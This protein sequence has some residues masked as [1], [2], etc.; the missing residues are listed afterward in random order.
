MTRPW[1]KSLL[2]ALLA[3][4]GQV[5]LPA[6]TNSSSPSF[7]EVYDLIRL[8]ATGVS[9]ADL[10]RAAVQGLLTALGPKISLVMNNSSANTAGDKQ[11]ITETTL[12]DG[13]IAYLRITRV[14]GDLANAV[15]SAYKQLNSTN[16]INGLVVDLRY[17]K[18][19]DYEAATAT[20]DLFISKSQ[21]L[22]N[23]GNGVVSSHDKTNA[24]TIPV[25]VLVNHETA[26]AAEALAAMV[27]AA[28]A[29]LILGSPTAGAAMVMQDFPLKDG[30][31]LRIG[32]APITLGNG[33]TISTQGIK[34]DIDVTVSEEAERA[35][36]A[37]AFLVV[38][39]TNQ[40]AG[41]STN[42]PNGTNQS[43]QHV[44]FNEAELVRE[45]K[46]GENPEGE[47]A[48]RPPEPQVPVVSDP[49]LAR[50]LDLLKGLAVV[51]LNNP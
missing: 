6:Q 32:S 19:S 11:P 21:P 42:Q 30:A 37:D 48:K 13:D 40:L 31:H 15:S 44:R 8:H 29:G 17:A 20:A 1:I 39:K 49:A 28:G 9:D 35:F 7:Q 4:A 38:S 3:L 45:H 41:T 46:A 5:S 16:K 43:P 50:A 23:W 24:F 14:D 18:G 34:P 22:L 26:G 27:R 47:T 36:Y 25:V 10:N 2:T 33:S 51:R 12:F